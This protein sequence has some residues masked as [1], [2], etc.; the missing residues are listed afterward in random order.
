MKLTILG[1]GTFEPELKRHSSSYLVQIKKENL[2]FDFGRGV[3]EQLM[4]AGVEYHEIDKIFITHTHAD[5]CSELSSFLQITLI[6]LMQKDRKRKLTIY[7]PRGIKKTINYI[8]HAFYLEDKPV[9]KISI[10]E[11]ND[12]NAVKSTNWKVQCFKVKHL[13]VNSLA[14]RLTRKNKILAYS[15][16]SEDCAGLRKACENADLAILESSYA[17]EANTRGHL[18]YHKVGEIAQIMNVK[19]VI[20]TH[21]S[22]KRLKETNPKKEI[23]KYYKGPVLIA[24]DLMQVNLYYT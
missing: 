6:Q 9:N 10:E 12:R 5:H 21:I 18:N 2:I 23:K 14:Y 8:L 24:E 19:K 4:K 22:A 15:G 17:N 11:L 16:D 3:I 1:S 7:G 20:A 13:G